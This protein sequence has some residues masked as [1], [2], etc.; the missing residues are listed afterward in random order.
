M[1]E[2]MTTNEDLSNKPSNISF[3]GPP[4]LFT[5]EDPAAYNDLHMR[6]FGAVMPS[7]FFE[8]LWT[9]DIIEL[10]WQVLRWRRL[11]V[12]LIAL[13]MRE[14]LVLLIMKP[15]NDSIM[16]KHNYEVGVYGQEEAKE[17]VKNWAKGDL[18]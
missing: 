3:F 9:R 11:E 6:V 7:D 10:T 14:A 2:P 1:E 8:E 12:T 13:K 17:L 16:E 18:S 5:G 4:S 15:L